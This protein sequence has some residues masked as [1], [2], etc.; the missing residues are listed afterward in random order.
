MILYIIIGNAIDLKRYQFEKERIIVGVDKGAF[1]SIKSN[2][3]L[4]Y[5]VGDFDSLNN[6]ERRFVF[7]NTKKI[8]QLDP[9]KDVTDTYYAYQRFNQGMKKIII[10]GGIQGSR[11]EHFLANINL[12]KLDDRIIIE[13][14]YSIISRY[15]APCKISFQK[16]QYRFYSFFSNGNSV[17][18]LKGFKFELDN[19]TLLDNDTL[20]ISNE[21]LSSNGTLDVNS[22]SCILVRSKNDIAFH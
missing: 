13:D 10:L 5:A 9:V 3:I 1:L 22:G 11:I 12:L 6:D 4:D 15:D 7:E 18:S 17:I 2:I 8:S 20:C 21:L 19:Y 14:D 16:D